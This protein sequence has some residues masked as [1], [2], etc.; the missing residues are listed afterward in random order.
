MT[1]R[2]AAGTFQPLQSI[3]TYSITDRQIQMIQGNALNLNESNLITSLP[4]GSLDKDGYPVIRGGREYEQN[5]E[6]EGIQYT[7]AF[8]TR[9]TNALAIP[10]L[11]LQSAQLTPGQ[12]NASQDNYGTGT[13][14]LIAKRGTYPAFATL[15]GNIG[16]PAFRH[17][18]NGEWGFALPNG[19]FSGYVSIANSDS[20]SA[21]NSISFNCALLGTCFSQYYQ[22]DRE[23]VGNFI[24]KFGR[25]NNMQL[26][27]FINLAQ[28][29]TDSGSVGAPGFNLCFKTCDP[30]FLRATLNIAGLSAPPL[31]AATCPS[32]L[33]CVGYTTAPPPGSSPAA[34]AAYQNV[35]LMQSM[36]SLQ[37]GQATA[38]ETL[39]QAGNHPPAMNSQPNNTMKLGYGWHLDR[40]TYLQAMLFH[41]D[42]V[43]YLNNAEAG[44]YQAT[45]FNAFDIWAGGKR[46]GG[47]IDLTKQL[48][49]K[50][51]LKAGVMYQYLTPVY[52]QV[53]P[54]FGVF[55][56]EFSPNFELP[57]FI[58]QASCPVEYGG[59][60]SPVCG[61]IYSFPGVSSPQKITGSYESSQARR[62]DW[63]YYVDDTWSPNDKLIV[64]AGLRIDRVNY[65]IPTPA[66][67]P[68]TC[69]SLYLP[70][71][72]SDANGVL[73]TTPS[74]N[75]NTQTTYQNP[76]TGAIVTTPNGVCPVA[77]FPQFNGQT[78]RPLVVEPV[79]SAS[80]RMGGNDSVRATW[81]RSVEFVNLSFVDF[82]ADPGYF[83]GPNGA[84]FNIP[85]YGTN[86]G[87][88]SD[89]A[90]TNYAEQLYWDNAQL[91]AGTVP[92][93]P[94]RPV[95]FTNADFS[96]E[97]RFTRGWMNGVQ[98]KVTPWYRRAHDQI[99]IV[100]TIKSVGDVPL[101]DPITGAYLYNPPTTTNHGISLADGL[102]LQ[103]TK[104]QPYGLSG[105]V[106]FTYQNEFT[107]VIPGGFFEAQFP[108]IPTPSALL[109]NIYRV[110]FLSP[111]V[112]SFDFSYQTH[113]G[114]R[115]N[116]RIQW[117]VGY[118][119][120]PGLIAA[121]FINGKP[122]NVPFTNASG[123]VAS[124]GSFGADQ[125][126]DPMNPGS[127]FN[128][129]IVATRGIPV[130]AAAG[131]KL[132]HP[133]SVTNLAI[134]YD[135]SKNW[136]AGIDVYNVFG[137]LYGGPVL[138]GSY[139]PVATGIS[140]PLTGQNASGYAFPQYG[141]IGDL[142]QLRH[143]R[144]A[145]TDTP[146]RIRSY[147]FYLT[148]KL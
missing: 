55:N 117:N 23:F 120:S 98:F 38:N 90:C 96:W 37:R 85:G 13:F 135:A 124:L 143:G 3:D 137:A 83:G 94:V 32:A 87:P 53:D 52:D 112:A 68:A 54:S 79:L 130:T 78:H 123:V 131:G 62:N 65:Q 104:E 30:F 106:S 47:R 56:L 92:M 51:L 58:P 48:S 27:A 60:G 8:T 70:T 122:Y 116:P 125:Y 4:G 81:G 24:Y 9:F 105:Q 20:A 128:P 29:T 148:V 15:Q 10:G 44:G 75:P 57:D 77:T 36:L 49:D 111:F 113:S 40:S 69:T 109:G 136:T 72:Q 45:G 89:Q 114:W 17:G 82:T 50:N 33:Q 118:P 6:F 110:G 2:S 95:V 91:V 66:I 134:E 107:S 42:A 101:T 142:G 133:S 139:Q 88:L 64:E 103:F 73:L 141:N 11:A 138:N 119:I 80:Y 93:M 129:N 16:G 46:S 126:V 97:H 59:P 34:F 140:G 12:G 21:Y 22:S 19:H 41:T 145:Y 26:Q 147:Y 63:A 74:T 18:F 102:E 127:F 86:C 39:A 67:D 108:T 99:A 132:S 84:F 115:I 7:D 1:S 14:N 5:L 43:Q 146:N 121:G 144:D 100:T 35:L 61:Y 71:Y 25:D 31:T 76:A 28:H